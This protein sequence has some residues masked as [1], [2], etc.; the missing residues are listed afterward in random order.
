[1]ITSGKNMPCWL[2][3]VVSSMLL[4]L[5]GAFLLIGEVKH[6]RNMNAIDWYG[7]ADLQCSVEDFTTPPE[8]GGSVYEDMKHCIRAKRDDMLSTIHSRRD[9]R[10]YL[11][12]AMMILGVP[13]TIY[14]WR[15]RDFITPTTNA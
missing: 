11:S 3:P 13:L 15:R 6:D 10:V 4:V 2:G 8:Q 1:M 14:A 12:L 5:L 7:L 9:R